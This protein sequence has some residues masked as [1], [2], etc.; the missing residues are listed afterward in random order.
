V[1]QPALLRRCSSCSSARERQA[2]ER[3]PQAQRELHW[4]PEPQARVQRWAQAQRSAE[5]LPVV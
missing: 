2:R 5:V 4:V 3:E 1:L